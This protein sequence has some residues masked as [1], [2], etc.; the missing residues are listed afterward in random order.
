MR[1]MK[2]SMGYVGL[3]GALALLWITIT[4]YP[5]LEGTGNFFLSMWVVSLIALACVVIIISIQY[6]YLQLRLAWQQPTNMPLR[7]PDL[8]TGWSSTSTTSTLQPYSSGTLSF[9]GAAA[10]SV[11]GVGVG[12]LTVTQRETYALVLDNGDEKV[13]ITFEELKVLKELAKELK[14]YVG[15]NKQAVVIDNLR[16]VIDEEV[17]KLNDV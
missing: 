12:G 9:G 6:I 13:E 11:I 7:R 15:T 2:H 16:S 10:G 3:M 8:P 17:R 4:N 1:Y 14:G 5:I